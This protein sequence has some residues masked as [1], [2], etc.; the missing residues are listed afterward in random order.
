MYST[1]LFIMC[2]TAIAEAAAFTPL[3]PDVPFPS[4]PVRPDPVLN[5]GAILQLW[6][7]SQFAAMSDPRVPPALKDAYGFDL[8]IM[9]P[10]DA[11]NSMCNTEGHGQ[12][13]NVS[14]ILS[15]AQFAGGL[16]AFTALN[17]SIIFYTSIMHCGH[18]PVWENG[19][20]DALHPDWV[21]MDERNQTVGAYGHGVL[22]PASAGAV[23]YTLGYTLGLLDAHPQVSAFMIDNAL[24][25]EVAQ[26]AP[27]APLPSGFAPS[28][29]AS[30]RAYIDARFGASSQAF[31]G[32]PAAQAAAPP[33]SARS[34]TAP[35]PLFGVWKLWR[36]RAYAEAVARFRAALHARNVSLLANTAFWALKWIQGCADEMQHLD[37]VISES[38]FDESWEMSL[39][40]GLASTLTL[41]RPSLNYIAVFNQSCQSHYVGALCPMRPEA[42]VRGQVV[43]SFL[44]MARPWLVAWGL[45]TLIDAPTD[46]ANA[47]SMAEV[48]RLMAFR[49]AHFDALFDFAGA[50]AEQ[51]AVR[52]GVLASYRH[53][54]EGACVR[55]PSRTLQTLG[56]AFRLETEVTI[57]KF[58]SL[59]APPTTTGANDGPAPLE[60]LLCDGMATLSNDTTRAI[61]A[62]VRRG[63]SLVATHRCAIVD[64]AGRPYPGPPL[65]EAALAPASGGAGAGAALF[66]DGPSLASNASAVAAM[67]SYKT[68]VAPRTPGHPKST[69][70]EVAPWWSP[71]RP[72]R[73]AVHFTNATDAGGASAYGDLVLALRLPPALAA[74][75]SLAATLWTPYE[76]APRPVAVKRMDNDTS[77]A[78]TVT[79]TSPPFYGIVD[80]AAAAE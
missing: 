42:V 68:V 72:D 3:P 57:L 43:G 61:A 37:A 50:R 31:L 16:N 63:G 34:A 36:S 79:V 73:L 28:A 26:P 67:L 23:N 33:A 6:G 15:P 2:V 29:Q 76:Q 53:N 52:V 35:S 40:M 54:N 74:A 51:K 78:I 17:M 80:V 64:A 27:A 12:Q 19:T 21:Q 5:R 49:A 41:G 4:L 20:L 18:A 60:L 66:V 9:L 13:C 1:T 55:P 46:A 22:S 69:S 24:W 30:F 56:V 59:D 45:S 39:K 38:H 44:Q 8:V 65:L 7:H 25:S 62:W 32:V 14:D 75:R 77:S 71:A 58:G 47:A 10:R 48:S 70:W 11:H